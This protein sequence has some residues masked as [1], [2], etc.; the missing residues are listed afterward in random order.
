VL[1]CVLSFL[2]LNFC[3]ATKAYAMLKEI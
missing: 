3:T 2:L 1:F